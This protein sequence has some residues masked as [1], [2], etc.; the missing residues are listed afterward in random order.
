MKNKTLWVSTSIICLGTLFSNYAL[1]ESDVCE[2]SAYSAGPVLEDSNKLFL[3]DGTS[4]SDRTIVK[5]LNSGK[6]SR[7]EE[8][9]KSGWVITDVS[10][11]RKSQTIPNWVVILNRFK[12]SR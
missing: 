3:M 7:L 5:C 1:A 12:I 10:S 8:L 4:T 2:Q 6:V 9:K 11:F